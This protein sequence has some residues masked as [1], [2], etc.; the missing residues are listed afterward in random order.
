[1]RNVLHRSLL[2]APQAWGGGPLGDSRVVEG[3]FAKPT[4][5]PR[6]PHPDRP[7]MSLAGIRRT[8]IPCSCSQPVRTTSRSGR[9]PASCAKPSTS[10]A[11]FRAAQVKSRARTGPT[12]CWRRKRTP[13]PR[14]RAHSNVSGQAPDC[15]AAVAHI[16]KA[17][18][19]AV[20]ADPFTMQSCAACSPSPLLRNREERKAPTSPL[21]PAAKRWGGG[22][23]AKR[24]V[25]GSLQPVATISVGK[26]PFVRGAEV[27]EG[28]V[29]KIA[30]CPAANRH[31]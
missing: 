16:L 29:C 9:S 8:S 24:V 23:L 19:V 7:N 13:D 12:G 14:R 10:I 30:A 18:S 4:A 20:T 2:P 22:P 17:L 28:D 25:E 27:G 1:M 21:L 26:K 5:T 31:A 6:P 15:V 3:L 11:S